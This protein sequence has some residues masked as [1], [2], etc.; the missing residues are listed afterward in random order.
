MAKYLQ[1]ES[2]LA[3]LKNPPSSYEYPPIDIIGALNNVSAT[4][5]SGGFKSQYEFDQAVY[6][7]AV[8]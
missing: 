4:A 6:V 2:T 5:A 8:L 1:F 7:G 3:Y